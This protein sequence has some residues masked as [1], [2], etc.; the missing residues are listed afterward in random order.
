MDVT[1]LTALCELNWTGLFKSLL[2]EKSLVGGG[3][4][5]T[6]YT[7]MSDDLCSVKPLWKFR[8]VKGASRNP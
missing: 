7:L 6:F 3:S 5:I 2:T 8:A 1:D 4:S